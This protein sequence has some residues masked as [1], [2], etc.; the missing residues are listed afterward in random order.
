MRINQ[1]IARS[2]V[3]SRR[4]AEE[5]IKAGKVTLNGQLVTELATEV[6]EN[7]VVGVEGKTV[8]PQAKKYYLLNKP[9]LYTTTKDDPYALHT[10]M[11]LLPDDPSLF[12]VGR[13]DRDTTGLIIITNDGDFGQRMIH[14]SKKIEKEYIVRTKLPITNDQLQMLEEGLELEDGT[15]K[16]KA[17]KQIGKN[18]LS[19]VIE[20]GRKRVVRRM[21]A[22]VGNKVN[23]LTRVRIGK[24]TLDVPPGQYRELTE[25]EVAYF[26]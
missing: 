18:E 26:D 21:V 7:D 9:N 24:L 14:P 16:P 20:M 13:L 22:A 23:A 10:I 2:G 17:V 6:G 1:Y 5:L 11:E 15:A 19:L 12:P 8:T 25:K 4:K 3:T